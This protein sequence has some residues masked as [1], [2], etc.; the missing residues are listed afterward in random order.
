MGA[1]PRVGTDEKDQVLNPD[2]SALMVE[3]S[4]EKIWKAL[5]SSRR[6]SG[7]RKGTKGG[8]LYQ[9]TKSGRLGGL[10]VALRRHS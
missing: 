5:R 2:T 10:S 8:K 6:P 7:G 4:A 9:R 1:A 3:K